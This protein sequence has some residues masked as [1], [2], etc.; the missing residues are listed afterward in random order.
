MLEDIV[1]AAVLAFI[2][3]WIIKAASRVV[4]VV[5]TKSTEL[6]Y[7]PGDIEVVLSRCYSLFPIENMQFNGADFRRGMLVRVV[8]NRKRTIEGEFVGVNADNM[9]CFLTPYSII[10]HEIGNI[11]EMEAV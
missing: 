7:R 4:K 2:L 10:A 11:E 5:V 8:T 9:V 1:L 3:T 6:G